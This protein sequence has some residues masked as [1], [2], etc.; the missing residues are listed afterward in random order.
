MSGGNPSLSY[1][2]SEELTDEEVEQL[3]EDYK[4]LAYKI[5][6]SYV[7]KGKIEYDEAMSLARYA[8]IKCI[9]SDSFDPNKAQFSTY[10][11]Q[12]VSNEIRMFL[13]SN[14][15][16]EFRR[17][18]SLNDQ[19]EAVSDDGRAEV[20]WIDILENVHSPSPEERIIDK[21]DFDQALRV[22]EYAVEKMSE[23]EERVLSLRIF[24]GMTYKEIAESVGISVSYTGKLLSH[25][26]NKLQE[27]RYR[28]LEEM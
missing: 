24:T 3:V 14:R 28:L 7:R 25:A 13:R 5:A 8:L 4:R 22:F 18:G 15:T 6:H 1:D 19:V 21:A 16:R 26:R 23:K 17:V 20:E 11:G 12:A 2:V 9:R 27:E 10:V